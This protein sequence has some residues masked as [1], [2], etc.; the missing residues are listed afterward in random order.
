MKKLWKI[1]SAILLLL[2]TLTGVVDVATVSAAEETANVTINKRIWKDETPNQVQNT[3]EEMDFG[4]DPLAGAG[5]TV[6]DVTDA[7]LGLIAGGSSQT[8]AVQQIVGSA[9]D[10]TTNVVKTEQKTD[11]NGQTT[12]EGLAL[13][14][15]DKDKVYMFVETSTPGNV[16]VTEKGVPIVLAM[17]IYKLGTDGKFTDEI[18]TNIHVYPKN[19][20]KTDKKEVA[21]KEGLTIVDTDGK[22]YYNVTTGD[23]IDFKL[24][25]NI[26]ADI[27]DVE[28]YS[29]MDTPTA[30]LKLVSDSIEV[31]GL[32]E[33]DDYTI[34]AVGNGFK[35]SL[36][37]DSP[38]VIAKAGQALEVTYQMQLTNDLNP[39]ELQ[40]NK[41]QVTIGNDPQSELVP[42]DPEDPMDPPAKFGTGGKK[43]VKEDSQSGEGLSGAE[44]VVKQGNQ[45]AKFTT[46]E[47]DEYVFSEWVDSK[48]GATRVV[49]GSEGKLAVIGLKDG[50]YKLEETRAPSDNYVLLDGDIEFTVKQGD[51]GTQELTAVKN[52]RKGLLPSTGGNGIYAFL[53]IGALLMGIAYVWYKKSNE[54]TEV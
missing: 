39:D 33:G 36:I 44:F 2:P 35:L 14:V 43:F 32:T 8:E 53:I 12:F 45:Y 18:N 54:Q 6:Y 16:S 11:E 42:G 13:K 9:S 46:N 10:H 20:T 23:V 51:Y 17:P 47:K 31:A 4:G 1:L 21:N 25:L 50:D 19:E 27:E 48:G 26:P 3:G 49:S 52:T 38:N 37:V 29:V 22:G 30:G 24:T 28:S 15:G 40:E 34:E 7:Y 41:A 5:F